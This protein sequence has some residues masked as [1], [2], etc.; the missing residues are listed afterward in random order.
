MVPLAPPINSFLNEK[1]LGNRIEKLFASKHI[2]LEKCIIISCHL[3]VVF[4]TNNQD[5]HTVSNVDNRYSYSN[6]LLTYFT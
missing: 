3:V 2:S 1:Q 6:S 4:A 5:R